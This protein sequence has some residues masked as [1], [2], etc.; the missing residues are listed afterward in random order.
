[1]LALIARRL[2]LSVA[3][4]M[5]VAVVVFAVTELLPGDWATAYFGR[6]ATPERLELLRA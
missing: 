6:E 3:T 1:M 4:L 2:L 5:I